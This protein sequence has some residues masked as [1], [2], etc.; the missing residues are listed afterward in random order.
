MALIPP[1]RVV[2]IYIT[3]PYTQDLVRYKHKYAKGENS[4]K[5]GKGSEPR[6]EEEEA[7]VPLP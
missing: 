7:A 5:G 1:D 6:W 3:P 4:R 2:L